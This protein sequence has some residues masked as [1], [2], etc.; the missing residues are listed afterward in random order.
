MEERKRDELGK[1]RKRRG[2]E[3]EPRGFMEVTWRK[4]KKRGERTDLGHKESANKTVNIT[5]SGIDNVRWY[6]KSY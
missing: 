6:K 2:L 3:I 4:K 1:N 5:A